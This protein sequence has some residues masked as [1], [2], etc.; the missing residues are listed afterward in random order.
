MC[1]YG[2]KWAALDAWIASTSAG[3]NRSP[4]HNH[5]S[6]SNA[7]LMARKAQAERSMMEEKLRLQREQIAELTK[8]NTVILEELGRL[9]NHLNPGGGNT[10]GSDAK[11]GR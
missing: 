6:P 7:S 10:P 2:V 5:A 11:R 8:S 3:T 4:T 1:R 9:R